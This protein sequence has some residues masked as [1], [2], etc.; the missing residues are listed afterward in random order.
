MEFSRLLWAA[1]LICGYIVFCVWLW[2]KHRQRTAVDEIG[3]DC[4]L[5]GWA[6]QGGNAM[7]LAKELQQQLQAIGREVLCL[8]LEQINVRSLQQ[9]R[10]HLYVASTHDEG[11]PPEHARVF[12]QQLVSVKELRGVS[13]QVLGLGDR[14]YPLFCQF[15]RDL[16]DALLER[17][18]HLAWP[19]LTVDNQHQ[20]DIAAWRNTLAQRF[21]LTGTTDIKSTQFS[22]ILLERELLNPQSES[23]GLYLLRFAVH[24]MQWQAGDTVLV[25]PFNNPQQ[26]AREYSI[27]NVCGDRLEL[28]VRV[29]GQCSSWLCETLQPNEQVLVQHCERPSFTALEPS[30]PAIFIGAGSGMA[31]L[32][33][34][35]LSR[36]I[37]SHNWLIFGERCPDNDRLLADELE[38]WL[39]EGRLQYLSLAFS[40]HAQK[41]TYV[42]DC[43]NTHQARLREWLDNG[44]VLYLCGSLQ[45]LGRSVE[46]ELTAL[47]GSNE[48]A[49]LKQQGRYKADVY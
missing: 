9:C 36:P 42:Q 41:P 44:A 30:V 20:G 8:P 12:L 23:P 14:R 46:Q 15:A 21:G 6:S 38:Q 7:R 24:D 1:A 4:I 27:A 16:Q 18:A 17:G 48:L 49:R 2:K 45:G 29:A 19:L 43:L 33:G 35:L 22:A 34:Q 37:G 13:I 11:Q 32:R 25:F 39:M 5:L 47:L 31:G 28:I 3:T 26:A 40:R 10:T